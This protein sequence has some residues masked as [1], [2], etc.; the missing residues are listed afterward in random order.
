[1]NV[2]FDLHTH[3]SLK[4]MLG[5]MDNTS[6]K[7]CWEM[8]DSKFLDLLSGGALG[9]QSSLKQMKD[10]NVKIAVT[11]LYSLEQAF[12]KNWLLKTVITRIEKDLNK[13]YLEAIAN[14][15][16]SPFKNIQE[17][18]VHIRDA[19]KVIS[20]VKVVSSN[21]EIEENKINLVLSIEGLHCFQ[22]TYNTNDRNKLVKDITVNLKEFINNNRVLYIGLTHLTQNHICTH[23]Y[24]MK[25]LKD[26]EFLPRGEGL[27]QEAKNIIDICYSPTGYNNKSTLIDIKHMGIV[28]RIQFYKY[29]AEKGYT[30]IPIVASHIAVTGRSFNNIKVQK[31]KL[32][33]HT[34]IYEVT[35]RESVSEIT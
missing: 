13:K 11:A 15:K 8:V 23:T 32:S 3:T 26:K 31:P 2:N 27:T 5:G 21:D 14:D 16:V 28:S 9:S 6:R 4:T 20:D 24:A 22:N 33:K 25:L 29:R 1:M 34:G 18:L 12:A 10:G 35:H 19:A 7:S 30:N 17:E